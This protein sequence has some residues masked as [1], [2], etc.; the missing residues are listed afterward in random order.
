MLKSYLHG[1]NASIFTNKHYHNIFD[2][3]LANKLHDWIEKYPHG[4]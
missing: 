4:I 3:K 1:I 2:E